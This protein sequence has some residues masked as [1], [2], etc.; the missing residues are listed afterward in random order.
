V[1]DAQKRGLLVGAGATAV[2]AGMG[3]GAWRFYQTSSSDE[4]VDTL[5]GLTYPQVAA[6]EPYPLKQLRDKVVVVNFWATWCAPCVEEMPEL[7]ELNLQWHKQAPEKARTIGIAVD[8]F[9]A[10]SNFYKK[11]PVSYPL[12]PAGAGSTELLRL[13]GNPGG[14]LPFTLIINQ[15]N[16][17]AARILGRFQAEKLDQMVKQLL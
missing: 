11:I 17:V 14:G 7:S 2:L 10:V 6:T 15:K 8:N 12:L 16:Q 4:A 5:W 3:F 1:N 9:P 13:F